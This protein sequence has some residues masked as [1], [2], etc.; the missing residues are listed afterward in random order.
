MQDVIEI[1]MP[2]IKSEIG[3][4]P[5]KLNR[6]LTDE[7][8]KEL[9]YISKHHDLAHIVGRG[10]LKN[11]LLKNDEIGA[12]FKQA[13]HEATF[14][15]LKLE[16]TQ[17][18][19][20]QVFEVAKV[21][22]LP[23]K[24]SVIRY[25]YPEPWMRTSC[26]IDILVKKE[27]LECASDV[28]VNNLGFVQGIH[29]THDISFFSKKK[30]VHIELHY[31]LIEEDVLKDALL[32]HLWDVAYPIDGK[33]FWYEVPDE[34]FYYYHIAHMAKHYKQSGCGFRPFVDI[35]VLNHCVKFDS[36][37]RKK[38]LLKGNFL[39]FANNAE[40]LSEIWF[41]NDKHDDL[42]SLMEEF[43]ACSGTYGSHN[44]SIVF[45]QAREGNK[46]LQIFHR[47]FMPYN[48][49]ITKYPILKKH[50][51]L[52]PIYEIKRWIELIFNGRIINSF[53]ELKAIN[54]VSV[55]KKSKTIDMLEQLELK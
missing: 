22:F 3:K 19:V 21:P 34:Y 37:K 38:L 24:G 49:I 1:L 53:D 39:V 42:T 46:I 5:L 51:I 8:L 28:L 33:S 32:N 29:A 23:L 7:D 11:S 43:I 36:V 9:Y 40:K 47:I 25:M 4:S 16:K 48:I 18:E 41:G 12:K 45:K 20:F 54:N 50:P 15:Y 30:E 17:N 13:V 52:L 31:D 35:W 6:V 27:D 2:I 14:R 55:S 26:D 44:N 10:L